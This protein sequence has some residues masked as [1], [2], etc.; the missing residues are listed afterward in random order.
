[1][2]IPV[3]DAVR[4]AAPHPVL[5]IASSNRWKVAEIG[6]MLDA[7]ALEVRPQP[8]GLEI[9]ETGL[10]YRENAR[11]KAETVARLT[12]QWALGDDSGLEVDALGGAPGLYS[13]RYA[14]TDHERIHRLLHALGPTPYRS[15]SFN[16]AMA[17]ADPS[18]TTVL[19]AEGICRGEILTAPQGHGGGYD[20]IFW[21]REA[22]L[23]YAELPEHLRH[24]LGSR[25]KAARAL[26]PGL[27]HWLRLP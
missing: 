13:A 7:V 2:A 22:G 1:M 11:L 26:A 25:G 12:G 27:R 16:S 8:D 20:P 21:V 24:K 4:P 10:T 6:A 19:E 15:A 9:E 5:V 18:G 17:L 14:P 23:S 3:S